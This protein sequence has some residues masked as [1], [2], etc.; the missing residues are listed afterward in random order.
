MGRLSC[1]TPRLYIRN[2]QTRPNLLASRLPEMDFRNEAL[3]AQR[4]AQLLEESEFA[5]ADVVIP[6]PYMEHT[7]RWAA[8]GLRL[9]LLHL[10]LL[11]GAHHAVDSRGIREG[12]AVP[13]ATQPGRRRR[14]LALPAQLRMPA[15][16]VCAH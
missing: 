10:L 4:M 12:P 11:H 5:A 7:T 1:G 8:G 14:Q 3:N 15:A 6:K 13:S 16:L 2:A 9:L